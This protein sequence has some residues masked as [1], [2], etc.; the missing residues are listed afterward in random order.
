M[1]IIRKFSLQKRLKP[2]LKLFE[3]GFP[4]HLKLTLATAQKEKAEVVSVRESPEEIGTSC[5]YRGK[6]KSESLPRFT[7][8]FCAQFGLKVEPEILF[9]LIN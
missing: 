9:H 7:F 2:K 3:A 4:S 1:A 5:E 8:S 6:R